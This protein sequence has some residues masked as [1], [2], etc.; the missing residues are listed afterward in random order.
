MGLAYQGDSWALRRLAEF[1]DTEAI[2]G[3]A[4]DAVA[5]DPVEA[6]MWHF[7]AKHFGV[8]LTGSTLNAYHDGG[9]YDVSCTT[10]IK[11]DRFT[12]LGTRG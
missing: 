8:D 7:L 5:S 6:W 2:R 12:L 9:L 1:G 11:A 4:Q 3:L 10:T